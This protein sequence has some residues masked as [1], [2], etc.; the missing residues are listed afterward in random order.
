MS[1]P[2][3]I[4]PVKSSGKKSRLSKLLGRAEAEEFAELL[5][6][7]VLAAIGSAGLL[8]SCYV[9]SSDPK[10]LG[11]AGRGGANPV[12]EPEDAGVNSAVGL[13][14]RSAGRSPNAMVIPGDL[15]MLKASEV[16]S[17]LNTARWGI[18]VAIA[19]SSAFDGTNALL[20]PRSA[21][22]RLS[23]DDNSF[24]NHLSNAASE[25]LSVRVCA[26]PGLMFDVDSP[27]DFR[28]LARSHS[29]RRS[30]TFAREH[31]R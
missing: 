26:L 9:V 20:F 15:P 3:V 4:V 27:E 12:R 29:K 7:D 19:P 10:I 24:W 30:V 28:E 14:L 22:L 25:R 2:A 17:L 5:F 18:D 6:A 16:E 23:I 8:R 1:P 31:L 13:G 21:P 11:L